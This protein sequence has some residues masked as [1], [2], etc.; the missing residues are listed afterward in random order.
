MSFVDFIVIYGGASNSDKF[1][2][3]ATKEVGRFRFGIL[4]ASE[5]SRKPAGW[6]SNDIAN[7]TKSEVSMNKMRSTDRRRHYEAVGRSR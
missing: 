1:S 2:F 4:N 5:S 7:K 6:K 3:S